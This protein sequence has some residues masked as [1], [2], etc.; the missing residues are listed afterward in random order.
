MKAEECIYTSF[1]TIVWKENSRI[2]EKRK[3]KYDSK[4]KKKITRKGMLN[5]ISIAARH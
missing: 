2:L 5:K 1:S 4:L 3:Q